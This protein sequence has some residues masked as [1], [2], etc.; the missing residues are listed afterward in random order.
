MKNIITAV[1]LL[2][3]FAPSAFNQ[4]KRTHPIQDE[5]GVQ[6][7]L[8]NFQAAWNRHDARAFAL[9]FAAA[10]DFTN[11]SGHSAHGRAAIEAHH[12][13]R[14]AT[15]FKDSKLTITETKIRFIKPDVAAVDARWKLSG[16][17]TE[18]GQDRPPR[19]GL[20]NFVMTRATGQWFITVMHN[21]D[22]PAPQ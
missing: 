2:L 7:V 13:P 19:Q 3:C 12:A 18:D 10:A 6:Q 17:K 11:V 9:V 15:K 1:C 14:F 8:T 22:F 4:S 21:M 16:L 20:L 5:Q